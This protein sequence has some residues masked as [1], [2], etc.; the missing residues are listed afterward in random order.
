[1]HKNSQKN[2][3]G[4]RDVVVLVVVVSGLLCGFNS[5]ANASQAQ[6]E[7]K[8]F[9]EFCK[10]FETQEN[11]K[12]CKKRVKQCLKKHSPEEC[13]NFLTNPKSQKISL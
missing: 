9:S 5:S 8:S 1:M 6:N 2:I 7:I 10:Q 13:R 12:K 11:R 4:L 3:M